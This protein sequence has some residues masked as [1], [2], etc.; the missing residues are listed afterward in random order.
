MGTGPQHQFL[1]QAGKMGA[2][3]GGGGQK[4]LN[5]IPRGHGIHTVGHGAIK[6]QSLGRFVSVN[7][8]GCSRQSCRPQGAFIKTTDTIGKTEPIPP[9]HFHVGQ[10]MMGQADGLGD[11]QMG[12]ARHQGFGMIPRFLV[13]L[14]LQI[15]KQILKALARPPQDHTKICHH[16]II[17]GSPR[18]QSPRRIPDQGF[19]AGFDVHMNIFQLAPKGKASL[20]NFHHNGMHALADGLIILGRKDAAIPQHFSMGEGGLNILIHH[21]FIH[22]QRYVDILE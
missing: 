5:K 15:P 21:L 18:V 22:I 4:F 20:S 13:Q 16:L 10:K 19:Q 9:K 11:L 17:A 1:P 3:N 7:G 2:G 14:P 6:S 8:K 12:I